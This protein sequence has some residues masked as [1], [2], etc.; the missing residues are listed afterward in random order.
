MFYCVLASPTTAGCL[1]SLDSIP[2]FS[3]CADVS[4]LLLGGIAAVSGYGITGLQRLWW[5]MSALVVYRSLLHLFASASSPSL[6]DV[7]CE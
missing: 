5:R 7:L 4:A 6:W 3:I 2:F 1:M